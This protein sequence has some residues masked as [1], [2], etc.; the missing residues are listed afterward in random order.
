MI[1][2]NN[3]EIDFLPEPPLGDVVVCCDEERLPGPC[4]EDLLEE[5]LGHVERGDDG[6]QPSKLQH[7]VQ[8]LAH[9]ATRLLTGNSG[10]EE[11]REKFNNFTVFNIQICN[12]L[13]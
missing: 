3:T 6:G 7:Q 12:L 13:N 10:I 4:D 2:S 8:V 9:R 1:N 11:N 5:D